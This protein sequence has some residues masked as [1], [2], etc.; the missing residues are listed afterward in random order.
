MSAPSTT[1]V[2]A[3]AGRPPTTV[4]VQPSEQVADAWGRMRRRVD[5]VRDRTGRAA[6]LAGA[7]AA[8]TV[9]VVPGALP[10]TLAATAAVTAAGAGILRLQMP[11]AGHQKA[12]ATVLYAVPGVS[13]GVLLIAERLA[14]GAAWG[15][16][17]ALQVLGVAVW[18]AGT[19]LLRPARAARRMA[20]PPPPKA[21]PATV[22]G[23]VGAHPAAQWWAGHAAVQ[24]G[25][26]PGTALDDIEQTGQSAMR[27]VI[28]S[29]TAGEPVPEISIRRLSALLDVPEDLI[30]I[31][32]VPGRGA[33][34]RRLTIGGADQVQDADP[35]TVWAE[36]IAP[37]AMPG[38]VLTGIRVGKPG[39]AA[40]ADTADPTTAATAVQEEV[41]E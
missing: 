11:H 20:T 5:V 7:G 23:G 28:R 34:V 37:L 1:P 9:V 18:A 13:L 38:A 30:G 41:S 15:G 36:T 17:A 27:A 22:A 19:W 16:T 32:P 14:S 26:A 12:T 31:G 40:T 21:V 39:A 25:V 35:V 2:G 8:L 29:T 24:G 6:T 3:R 10:V 33:G 4:T